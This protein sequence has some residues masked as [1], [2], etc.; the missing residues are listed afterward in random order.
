MV[1]D[2]IDIINQILH[3]I[4]HIPGGDVPPV[5]REVHSIDLL[6]QFLEHFPSSLVILIPHNPNPRILDPPHRFS[7][8]PHHPLHF[9]ESA[10]LQPTHLLTRSLNQQTKHSERPLTYSQIKKLSVHRLHIPQ[11]PIRGRHPPRASLHVRCAPHIRIHTGPSDAVAI[12]HNRIRLAQRPH[13][14]RADQ[15]HKLR[16]LAACSVAGTV[17]G[18]RVGGRWGVVGGDGR[19]ADWEV[20][21]GCSFFLPF[22]EICVA[23]VGIGGNGDLMEWNGMGNY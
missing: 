7:G 17:G 13:L 21:H 15:A 4:P 5:E 16:P 19:D 20:R 11:T 6:T 14:A 10:S 2:P 8:L 12:S 3:V 9:L 18:G 23:S 1:R 22:L